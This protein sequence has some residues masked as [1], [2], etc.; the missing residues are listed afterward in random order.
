[1]LYF[2]NVIY[3]A[4]RIRKYFCIN[5]LAVLPFNLTKCVFELLIFAFHMFIYVSK[6]ILYLQLSMV[7]LKLNIYVIKHNYLADCILD[8]NNT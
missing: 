2:Y 5:Y 7:L 4:D 3:N 6:V 1:M 8:T